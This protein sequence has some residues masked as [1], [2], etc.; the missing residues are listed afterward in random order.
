MDDSISWLHYDEYFFDED[1]NILRKELRVFLENEIKPMMID[2]VEKA[3]FP[4]LAVE[5]LK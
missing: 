4:T 2:Y 3:E 5:K 1:T